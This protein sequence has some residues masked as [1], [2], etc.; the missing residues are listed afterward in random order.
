MIQH[1]G[2]MAVLLIQ[3]ELEGNHL[4]QKAGYL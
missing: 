1:I 2:A 4:H 3:A